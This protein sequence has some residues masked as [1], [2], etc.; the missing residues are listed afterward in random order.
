M[1][2]RRKQNREKALSPGCSNKDVGNR[3][4]GSRF[5][6]CGLFRGS[7]GTGLSHG[8]R[9]AQ[10]DPAFISGS[11]S[12][13]CSILD[14]FGRIFVLSDVLYNIWCCEM[15]LYTWC[16]Y[17]VFAGKIYLLQAWESIS[18]ITEKT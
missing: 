5:F 8:H 1:C 14:L 6:M 2:S 18:E 9:I 10:S 11:K 4:R 17:W 7:G 3:A 12:G 16:G 13:R 15:A